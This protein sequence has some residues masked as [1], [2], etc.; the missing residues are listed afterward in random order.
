MSGPLA[1]GDVSAEPEAP[2]EPPCIEVTESRDADVG[3]MLVRRA[4]PRRARRTVGAWCFVDHMAPAP[5]DGPGIGPH[6]HIGLHTVT[7]LLEG[8]LVHRDS[9]G[10]EQ[11]IRPGQL[12]VMTAGEGIAHAEE[13]AVRGA[14]HH[15]VQLWVAQ[16]EATRHGAP[17]FAHHA[18][19]PRLELDVG[20]ATVLVGTLDGATSPARTDTPLVG[21]DLALRGGGTSTVPLDP[22]HEHAVVVLDG[23][24]VLDGRRLTPGHLGYLGRGRDQLAI[25][26]DEPTRALLVGGEP[27]EATPLMWW[28]YVARTWD[29]VRAA[30][31]AWESGS[32]RFGTVPS[33]LDRIPSVAPLRR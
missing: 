7:W 16:P 25:A 33:S 5:A 9:L 17:A 11:P 30:H 27:F 1:P 2:V 14:R 21:V 6:P 13:T 24:V 3:G 19:L 32:D 10:T 31:D 4:L 18:E 22:T 12:N 29:E 20:T 15:G 23:A 28:N 8:E 26:A